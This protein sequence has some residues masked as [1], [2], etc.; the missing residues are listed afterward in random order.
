MSDKVIPLNKKTTKERRTKEIRHVAGA[1]VFFLQAL[2]MGPLLMA[3]SDADKP[4]PPMAEVTYAGGTVVTEPNP[5]DPKYKAELEDWSAV[6]KAR[7][8][9]LCVMRGI[10][11]VETRQGDPAEPTPD[12]LE[13]MRFVYGAAITH[14]NARN[15]WLADILGATATGFMNLC[16]GQ[17]EVTE[18]GLEE[19]EE[20]FRTS[21]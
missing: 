13:D 9:R 12:E 20:A 17:T 14:R 19:S 3:L 18:E 5:H 11:R 15:Y 7:L 10:K 16:M 2:P 21:D 6:Y 8:F 1:H 4:Q